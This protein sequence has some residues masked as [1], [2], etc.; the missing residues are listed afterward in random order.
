MNS[1]WN[2]KFQVRDKRRLF[3]PGALG[4]PLCGILTA[5]PLILSVTAVCCGPAAPLAEGRTDAEKR[6]A[7]E[8]MYR[9]FQPDFPDAP[10]I[11]VE[12]LIRLR[13]REDLLIVDVREPEER[14]V[15][16]IPGAISKEAFESLKRGLGD[17]PI[18]VHC[19]IGYRSAGYVEALKAEGIEAYNL[20]G[21]ILSWVHAGQ[22]VVDPEGNE[23]KRVH[24][25]GKRW[26][27]LPEE[28]EA[29]W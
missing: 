1:L 13:T 14:M 21:S 7:I 12:E 10:E 29:V 6:A 16:I 17:A 20:K 4:R 8:A 9:E 27:L 11:S 5:L 28:Y 23:T 24:V 25:Y 15:S 22:P 19:T 18:V 3:S 26:D 2:M